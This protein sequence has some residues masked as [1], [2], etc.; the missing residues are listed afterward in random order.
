[1]TYD[2]Y[3]FTFIHSYIILYAFI[4]TLIHMHSYLL[5]Y[6]KPDTRF[7]TSSNRSLDSAILLLQTETI[8]RLYLVINVLSETIIKTSKN[9]QG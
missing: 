5:A 1:M 2:I 6:K 8:I 4:H 7:G 9:K 3:I